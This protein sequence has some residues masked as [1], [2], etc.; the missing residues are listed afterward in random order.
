[1]RRDSTSPSGYAASKS[2]RWTAAAASGSAVGSGAA[3]AVYEALEQQVLP[4]F[5][6]RGEDG[7]PH[8]WIAHMREAMLTL[9]RQF[10][11]ARM[12]TDYI[13]QFYRVGTP[14]EV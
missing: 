4:A 3:A 2:S 14:S 7:L 13:E 1:M 10:S 8:T 5:Y 12:V 11:A 9:A 6:D